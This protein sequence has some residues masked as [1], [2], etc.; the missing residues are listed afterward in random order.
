M[1]KE[2][3]EQEVDATI[4]KYKA[5]ADFITDMARAVE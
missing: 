2:R 4:R 5:F 3:L 1:A